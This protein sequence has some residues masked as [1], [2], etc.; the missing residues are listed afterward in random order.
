MRSHLGVPPSMATRGQSSDCPF[1]LQSAGPH[2]GSGRVW[3]PPGPHG[4]LGHEEIQAGVFAAP[5][6]LLSGAFSCSCCWFGGQTLGFSGTVLSSQVSKPQA[7]DTTHFSWCPDGEHIVT[8]TC[9]PRLRVS[10]GFRIWHYTGSVLHKQEVASGSELWEVRWQLFPEGAF[11]ERTITYQAAPSELG[12]TQAPPK[13][14]Y[15]P[16][17][18]RHLPAKPSARLVRNRL[19]LCTFSDFCQHIRVVCVSRRTSLLRTRVPLRK[20]CPKRR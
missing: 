3:E 5:G 19:R 2:P 17:A 7:R 16:P 8:A 18:L 12:T 10:N 11:P 6:F 1:G 14:A 20:F 9:S 15:R 13:Q 4:G